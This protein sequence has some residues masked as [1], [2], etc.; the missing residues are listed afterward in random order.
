MR[1]AA[2]GRHLLG[3]SARM[4]DVRVDGL[5]PD[6][7][8]DAHALVEVARSQ[9]LHEFEELLAAAR[10]SWLRITPQQETR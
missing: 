8:L 9:H 5:H 3:R 10:E 4:L 1:A 7:A 6:V 2:D